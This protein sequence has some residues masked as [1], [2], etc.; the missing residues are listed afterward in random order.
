M[1][2]NPKQKQV[3]MARML[4]RTRRIKKKH[5]KLYNLSSVPAEKP[6]DRWQQSTLIST[7]NIH[8]RKRSIRLKSSILKKA[9]R[10]PPLPSE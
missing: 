9:D 5:P 7:I 8:L 6:M 2:P 1:N 3:K 10:V 4:L